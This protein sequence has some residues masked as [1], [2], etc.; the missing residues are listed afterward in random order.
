VLQL[1]VRSG[2]RLILML[3]GLLRCRAQKALGQ[4]T[5]QVH[6]LFALPL[7]ATLDLESERLLVGVLV[8]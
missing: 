1:L 7:S 8:G 5:R 3:Y 6:L 4:G 2:V